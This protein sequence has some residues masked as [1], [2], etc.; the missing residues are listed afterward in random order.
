M[1]REEMEDDD[2][3]N[4]GIMQGFMQDTEEEEDA[5]EE[6]YSSDEANSARILNRRPDSP[7]ILMNNLRG[8]MRSID[9]RRDEL[10]DLVG[11]KAATETPE[12]VLA[13]LQPVLAQ[14]AGIGALPQSQ[15]MAQGPQ[16]PMPLPPEGM[17][18]PPM[19]APPPPP[20]GAPSPS[21]DQV[22]ALMASA[23]SPSGGSQAPMI[24][25]DGQPI[26]PEGIPPIAMRDGGLV[27]RFKDGSDEE[28][29]TPMNPMSGG[30]SLLY[31]PE[32]MQAAEQNAMNLLTQ[33]P[34]PV[35]S[36]REAMESRMPE[37]EA[38]FA[39]NKD[40]AKANLLFS[41]AGAGLNLAANRGPGGEALRGSA[42]SRFAGAFSGIPAAVQAQ[43]AEIEK[44]R[45]QLKMLALQAGEKDRQRIEEMNSDLL[46]EQRSLLGN[47][48]RASAANRAGTAPS[49]IFGKGDWAMRIFNSDI[50]QKIEDGTATPQERNLF[51]SAVTDYTQPRFQPQINPDTGL[52]TGRTIQIPGNQLPPFVARLVGAMGAAGTPA[53]PAAPVAPVAEP[54]GGGRGTS[55]LEDTSAP[56]P[57]LTQGAKPPE[58]AA[59]N[60]LAEEE[61]NYPSQ[62]QA[63]A[64]PVSLWRNAKY[65][66]GPMAALAGVA[67]Q[68]PGTGDPFSEVTYARAQA[69]FVSKLVSEAFL[70]SAANSVTEQQ[71]VNSA[72][73]LKP[74]AMKDVDAYR[75]QLIAFANVAEQVLKSE[76]DKA[77][78]QPGTTGYTLNQQDRTNAR[79]RA[80]LLQNVITW[81]DL[82]PPAYSFEEVL[83]MP[84]G[85]EFLWQNRI[86]RTRGNDGQR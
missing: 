25:P 79:E 16:P 6:E 59:A 43:V 39:P 4:V 86:P 30:Q 35:P 9:A 7:E 58:A 57:L 12:E 46:T 63:F 82:P 68:I 71:M 72:L 29:V 5:D 19:G 41:I 62:Q 8:D 36:L 33:G 42:I 11:Y 73:Q 75:T 28:G 17:G 27:Q 40:M 84:P 13:M 61:K 80:K 2:V 50:T 10:A 44:G 76:L 78:D 54:V 26:P 14:Q 60:E 18:A 74:A 77:S 34:R 21:G 70:K 51:I 83:R 15:A 38:L 22:A 81:V 64:K 45:Q 47:V 24:G 53:A 23:G 66:A 48:L 31:S 56:A 52:P 49:S 32:L 65:V 67:T 69:N 37:Y 3:E 85:T 20:G 55:T 1:S